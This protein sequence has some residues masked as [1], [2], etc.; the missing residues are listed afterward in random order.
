MLHEMQLRELGLKLQLTVHLTATESS[1]CSCA[2]RLPRISF[3]GD[4]G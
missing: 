1:P 3:V 2:K 4:E